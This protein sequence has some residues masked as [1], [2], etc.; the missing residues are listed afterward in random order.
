MSAPA[1]QVQPGVKLREATFDDYVQIAAVE[2]SQ[3]LRARAAHEWTRLWRENPVYRKLGPGWPIG[4]VLENN[5]GRIVGSIGNVP[6][7]YEFRGRQ[8]LVS[9]GRAWS[10]DP[11]YR[12]FA[13][14]LMDQYFSQSNVDL[15]LNT[16][17]NALAAEGFGLFGSS[18]VPVG[19]WA[20]SAFWITGYRGFAE[21]AL[22][23]KRL[24]LAR[25]ARWPAAGVFYVKDRFMARKLAAPREIRVEWQT[26]FDERFDEFWN[27][28]KRDNPVFLG[29]RSREMLEWHF[30]PALREKR[31]WILTV[32]DGAALQAY[33]VFRRHDERRFGLTRMRL[34]D[35][36]SLRRQPGVLEAIL[37]SA[38]EQCRKQGV[39]A[40]ENVG[41]DLAKTRIIDECAPY[42][43]TLPAWSY[44]YR[45][46]DRP[47]QK[48]LEDP[49]AWDPSSFDGDAS[50]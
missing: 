24:P 36:Q 50:L 18:P 29:V 46:E 31:L 30:G 5:A 39:H 23:I 40:L 28:L 12:G 47:L 33:A 44:F 13:L 15:F 38:L 22:R 27:A 4:W 20:A 17:V 9:A 35:F 49:A 25:L 10:V 3:G 1:S 14:M 45:A 48:A 16:T 41:C 26:G 32:S 42:R 34:A 37:H 7:I 19:N 2:S 43:R 6:L 8:I 21:S 11:Q